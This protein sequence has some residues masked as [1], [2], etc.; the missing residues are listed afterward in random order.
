MKV[1]MDGLRQNM[2][3]DFN[4]L[5][6]AIDDIIE[7]ARSS[8]SEELLSELKAKFDQAA[9]NVN[10]LNCVYDPEAKGDFSNLSHLRVN[11]FD[12][13]SEDEGE[14]DADE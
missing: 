1:S 3:G 4:K 8:V 9:Q 6:F 2:T 13:G 10:I 12:D 14:S 11:S 7:D 5:K